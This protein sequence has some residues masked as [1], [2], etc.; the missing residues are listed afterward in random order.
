ML[1]SSWLPVAGVCLL[2]AMSPGPSLA[3]VIKHTV[4]GSRFQGVL[5]GVSHGAGVLLYALFTVFGLGLIMQNYPQAYF[6]IQT[7][8]AA[9]LLWLALKLL[10]AGKQSSVIDVPKILSSADSIRD[11]LAVA[12]LNPKIMVFFLALF[13]QF[14]APDSS[15]GERFIYAATAG[16]IDMGWYSLIAVAFSGQKVSGWLAHNQTLIN[17]ILAALLTLISVKIL[18]EILSD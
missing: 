4:N 12:L 18:F 9:Y 10:S 3:I 13:S 6:S 15:N 14:I 16:L 17:R 5:T 2:G 11:G 8:G 1:L 7:A